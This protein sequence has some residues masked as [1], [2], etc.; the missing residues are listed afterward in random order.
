MGHFQVILDY[1][2]ARDL[3]NILVRSCRYVWGIEHN[4]GRTSWMPYQHTLFGEKIDSKNI[5]A[6][7]IE[8][9]FLM[10]TNTFI[11]LIPK[12]GQT[13]HLIQTNI[14]PPYYINLDRLKGKQKY[15]LLKNKLNYYLEVEIPGASDY[16]TLISPDRYFLESIVSKFSD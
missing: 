1:P 9:E 8:M 6:R 15:D 3:E 7:N 12:I 10:D 4:E 11:E 5:L 14:Q 16:G 2:H 13:I